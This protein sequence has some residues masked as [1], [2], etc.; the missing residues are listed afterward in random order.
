MNRVIRLWL[1][2]AFCLAWPVASH[3]QDRAQVERQIEYALIDIAIIERE[4]TR[5]DV[6]DD[7][8]ARSL[9]RAETQLAQGRAAAAKLSGGSALLRTAESNAN[10]V[11]A[12]PV[13]TDYLRYFPDPV[14]VRADLAQASSDVDAA[15]LAGRQAGRFLML[16]GALD[17]FSNNRPPRDV[18]R[19][20]RLYGLNFQDIRDRMKLTFTD[21]CSA[22]AFFCQTRQQKFYNARGSYSSDSKHARETAALYF[23]EAMRDRFFDATGIGGSREGHKEYQAQL[24]EERAKREAEKA[25]WDSLERASAQQEQWEILAPVLGIFALIAFVAFIAHWVKRQKQGPSRPPLSDNHGSAQWGVMNRDVHP[26]APV[27]GIFLGKYAFLQHEND[28][29]K[30]PPV[31]T[32][33]ESHTLI[34]APTRTGKGTRIIIPTLLRYAGS[35]LV[36]DPKGE[37]AAVTG[38]QR[39]VI[40]PTYIL[41]PWGVL[42]DDLAARGL[43]AAR[44]NPLDVIRRDDVDAASIAHT[45]AETICARSGDPK[46]AYW[47]GSATA[48]LT[49]VLLWLADRDGETKSLARVRQI[50]TLPQERLLK[51]YFIPMAE[52]SSYGGAIAENIGPF[53]S[54]GDSRDLPSILRTLAEATRFISDERLKDATSVSDFDLRT[55]P[56]RSETVFLVIPPDRMKIQATWLRLMLAAVTHA[57]RTASSRRQTRGMLLIDELPALGR[58]PDLPNDLATMSGYGLDYTLIIQDVGQLKATYGD[59]TQSILANCAWKWLCNTRDFDSAKYVSDTLG[60]ATVGTTTVNEGAG[61]GGETSGKAYGEMGRSLLTPDEVMQLGRDKAIV[62]PPVGRPFLVWGLDYWRIRDEFLPFRETAMQC[63]YAH[64]LVIDPNPYAQA[65]NEPDNSV[66]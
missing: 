20:Q 1:L 30:T 44:Y 53:V 27:R 11:S 42:S 9:G 26:L 39:T 45:M 50:V 58:I 4:R 23:P 55:M 16:Q 59:Q 65:S 43:T 37:N 49:A 15:V 35:L 13:R 63:Y 64:P 34:M 29:V 36:I 12:A 66:Q 60:Q 56:H 10:A 7:F 28:H 22:L 21:T 57:F 48:I 3:A 25:Q 52:C 24:R 40:G 38:R 6:P 51:E 8:A 61:P 2:I 18:Q 47:E 46:N 19:R 33:P 32:T 17:G 54:S 62:L 31:F 5:S 41:N 14:R